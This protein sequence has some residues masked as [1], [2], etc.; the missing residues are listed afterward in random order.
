M[1]NFT[2]RQVEVLSGLSNG[3]SYWDVLDLVALVRSQAD[4]V[5]KVFRNGVLT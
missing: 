5:A 4:L 3:L 2:N 1:G